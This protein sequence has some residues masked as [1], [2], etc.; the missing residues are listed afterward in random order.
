MNIIELQL[1]KLLK[2]T[3]KINFFKYLIYHFFW[4][5]LVGVPTLLSESAESFWHVRVIGNHKPKPLKNFS[6][7]LK[8]QKCLL[9]RF[10]HFKY[11]IKKKEMFIRFPTNTV[12]LRRPKDTKSDEEENAETALMANDLFEFPNFQT[13]TNLLQDLPEFPFLENSNYISLLLS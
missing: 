12:F 8:I 7:A 2:K 4:E 13:G 3:F 6:V 11:L 10:P 1:K 5:L 9:A